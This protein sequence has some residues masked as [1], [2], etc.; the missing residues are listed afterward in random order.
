MK[1]KEEISSTH[2]FVRATS[3]QFNSTTN[4]T[5][6]TQS[7]AGVKEIIPGMRTDPKTYITTVGL[8]NN[9]DELLAIAKLSKPI[10]KSSSREALIKVKLDF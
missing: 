6:Y 9:A 2:Y 4:E 5:Y 1:R 8:Y 7:V 3:G 10:L